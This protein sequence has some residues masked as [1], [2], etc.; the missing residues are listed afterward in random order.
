MPEV[1]EG[2]KFGGDDRR[3]RDSAAVGHV[4]TKG[5]DRYFRWMRLAQNASPARPGVSGGLA[6]HH[7]L[8]L[9]QWKQLTEGMSVEEVALLEADLN[10]IGLGMGDKPLNLVGLEQDPG[11]RGKNSL[12][13]SH[14]RVHQG[15]DDI[16]KSMGLKTKGGRLYMGSTPISEIDFETR[17]GILIGTALRFEENLDNVQR[18]SMEDFRSQ[19]NYQEQIDD[20]KARSFKGKPMP[21]PDNI[22]TSASKKVLGNMSYLEA[23]GE[24]VKQRILS[25]GERLR[26]MPIIPPKAAKTLRYVPG[27]IGGVATVLGAAGDALAVQEGLSNEA[28]ELSPREQGIKDLQTASGASGLASLIPGPQQ[29]VVG[30]VSAVTGI[31]AGAASAFDAAADR[32]L[33]DMQLETGVIGG[34]TFPEGG[35][36]ITQYNRTPNRFER[37]NK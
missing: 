6:P 27:V 32:R 36:E 15:E 13:G 34:D 7:I 28:E 12:T 10:S 22:P 25:A 11:S 17:R 35:A 14:Y 20:I 37:R 5:D 8:G 16:V 9:A 30:G 29:A 31:A 24:N 18:E 23:Q 33:R 4:R 2:R 26:N 1:Y 3:A 19:P 21:G